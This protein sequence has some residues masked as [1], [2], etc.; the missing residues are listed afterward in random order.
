MRCWIGAHGCV[1]LCLFLCGCVL[2]CSWV[3]VEGGGLL[4]GREDDSTNKKI[5]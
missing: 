3:C 2:V 1:C 4:S 5:T